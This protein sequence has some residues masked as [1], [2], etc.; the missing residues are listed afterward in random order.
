MP[1]LFLSIL[2]T[3]LWTYSSLSMQIFQRKPFPS[4]KGGIIGSWTLY[5]CW[6][7]H[8]ISAEAMKYFICFPHHHITLFTHVKPLVLCIKMFWKP[9]CSTEELQIIYAALQLKC[10][11]QNICLEPLKEHYEMRWWKIITSLPTGQRFGGD[12]CGHNRMG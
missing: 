7:G 1:R 12:P 4:R 5:I 11:S 9:G 2:V 8:C 10:Y 3:V 6:A